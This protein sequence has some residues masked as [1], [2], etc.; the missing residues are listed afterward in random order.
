VLYSTGEYSTNFATAQFTPSATSGTTGTITE[1]IQITANAWTDP[2]TTAVNKTDERVTVSGEVASLGGAGVARAITFSVRQDIVSTEPDFEVSGVVIYYKVSTATYW[3]RV[4]QNFNLSYTP[5]VNQSFVFSGDIGV[6]GGPPN[7]DFIFRLRY[8]SGAESEYQYR[9]QIRV[10]SP[11]A[12]YPY[13]PFYG[14]TTTNELVTAY[15][16]QTTDQAPPGA[17]AAAANTKLGINYIREEVSNNVQFMR[18]LLLPPDAA[19]QATYRGAKISYRPVQAGQN[20]A[21]TSFVDKQQINSAGTIGPIYISPI[22]FDQTY[23][24][25][26]TPQVSSG[27]AVID[28]NNSLYGSGLIHNRTSAANYPADS[29]WLASFKMQQ[30]DTNLALRTSSQTFAVAN[31]TVSVIRCEGT[32]Q[33]GSYTYADWTTTT[34]NHVFRRYIRLQ[35]NKSTIPGFERLN[36]YRR[37]NAGQ[38]SGSAKYYGIGQWE[39]IVI[40]DATNAPDAN[41]IVTVN[42]RNAIDST[43][44]EPYYQVAGYPTTTPL[45]KTVAVTNQG[46]RK[47]VSQTWAHTELLLVVETTGAVASGKGTYIKCA[48]FVTGPVNL[49]S[50]NLPQIVDVAPYN[51]NFDAGF[52]RKLSDARSVI[53]ATGV[54][55]TFNVPHNSDIDLSHT[56]PSIDIRKQDG[57]S[58][59]HRRFRYNRW[60]CDTCQSRNLGQPVWHS[61]EFLEYLD[62][63]TSRSF[64]MDYR[65]S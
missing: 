25:I 23:E 51:T 15:G 6:S 46:S 36:I 31:P 56:Q 16:F 28:S 17:V 19:N 52:D 57:D 60:L 14:K 26:I 9:T 39:K 1:T 37:V 45:K 63:S 62:Q 54:C 47:P 55:F 35:Y 11:F 42:L 38:V 2:V 32:T 20:P 59:Q 22:L 61:L 49:I 53:A 3:D 4:V 33:A 48:N 8:K 5:G 24:L 21:L 7:Y 34:T 40:T 44:F 43:E 27:G 64:S 29:N 13:N 41:G 18:L 58:K 12:T 10:E 30:T 50:P 65:C